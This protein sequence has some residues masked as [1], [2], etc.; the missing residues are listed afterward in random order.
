M[1]SI[2]L[3]QSHVASYPVVFQEIRKL[4]GEE[5]AD[6]LVAHFGGGQPLYIPSK[7]KPEHRLC[8]LVGEPVMQQLASEFGGLTIEIP[9]CFAQRI[10]LRNRQILADRAAGMTQGD[11][12]RKYQLTVRAIRTI[13]NSTGKAR[14]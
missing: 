3:A 4:I 12:A 10:E 8:Q 5:A 14:R 6:K 1:R 9:R 2:A 11:I 13:T 7:V